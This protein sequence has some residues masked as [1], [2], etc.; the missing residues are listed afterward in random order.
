MPVWPQIIQTKISPAK[1]V[2][3][4]LLSSHFLFFVPA[5]FCLALLTQSLS[6]PPDRYSIE[7]LGLPTALTSPPW[8]WIQ[9]TAVTCW[10]KNSIST[11]GIHLEIK[12]CFASVPMTA[13]A[14]SFYFSYCHSCLLPSPPNCLIHSPCFSTWLGVAVLSH[15]FFTS[16]G[17]K[18]CQQCQH[19]HI[20]PTRNSRYSSE[21]VRS[22]RVSNAH[23][24]V[25]CVLCS[26]LRSQEP[27]LCDSWVCDSLP[28]RFLF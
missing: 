2:C 25:F 14:L 9:A 5:L 16:S 4:L 6:W 24:L 3:S 26:W 10:L 8:L 13:S 20:N 12:Q 23:S 21:L 7:N 17:K 19:W 22:L 27:L 1:I 11:A 15:L 28:A 18:C